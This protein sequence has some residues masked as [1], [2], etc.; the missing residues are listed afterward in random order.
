MPRCPRRSRLKVLMLVDDDADAER[1]STT[2]KV[3]CLI[4]LA[5]VCASPSEVSFAHGTNPCD[6]PPLLEAAQAL[7]QARDLQEGTVERSNRSDLREAKKMM[8]RIYER[9]AK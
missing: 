5:E 1:T 3:E 2:L 8:A 7:R 9:L 6:G 4:L